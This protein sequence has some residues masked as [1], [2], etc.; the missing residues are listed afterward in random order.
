M[1]NSLAWAKGL[2]E[3]QQIAQLDLV[4]EGQ[5]SLFVELDS[6]FVSCLQELKLLDRA[7]PQVFLPPCPRP[8]PHRF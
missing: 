8:L 3:P 2:L 1:E 4:K 7:H 5:D 6:L